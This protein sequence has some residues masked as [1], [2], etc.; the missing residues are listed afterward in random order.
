MEPKTGDAIIGEHDHR[1]L[2]LDDIT[3]DET[4]Q[5]RAQMLGRTSSTSTPRRCERVMISPPSS[6]FSRAPNRPICLVRYVPNTDWR[7][8]RSTFLQHRGH[9]APS[10]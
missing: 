10:R 1:P 3:V 8:P 6:Y 2:A 5:A 7:R 9:A 4:V